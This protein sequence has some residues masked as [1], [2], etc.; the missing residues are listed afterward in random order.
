[1]QTASNVDASTIERHSYFTMARGIRRAC[2]T[3]GALAGIAV[4]LPAS[5]QTSYTFTSGPTGDGF[6]WP[7]SPTGLLDGTSF[8]TPENL[9]F[10][11]D[12][13]N[14]LFFDDQ[15]QVAGNAS[16]ISSD[17]MWGNPT[18]SGSGGIDFDF[19]FSG[20]QEIAF[21][22]A[23][24]AG[25]GPGNTPDELFIYVED[26]EGRAMEVFW[27]LSESFPGFGGFDGFA[28]RITL[29]TIDLFDDYFNVDG[30]PFIDIVYVSI[31]VGDID[32][33]GPSS[34]FAIDNLDL[35]GGNGGGGEVFPSINGGTIDAT[36]V[37]LSSTSLRGV[38]TTT[39]GIEVTNSSTSNTTYSTQLLPG[40]G[41]SDG[42][43]V[44]NA[45]ILAGQ[46]LFAPNIVT[47]DRSLPSATYESDIRVINNG[48]ASDPDNDTTIR[49]RLA[50]APLLSAPSPVD[51]SLGE[52]V[53]LI[54]AAAPANGHR[55][56]VEVTGFA[57]AS[58]FSVSGYDIETPC[59]PGEFIEGDA[60]F[61]R[62][63]QLSGNHNGIFTVALQMTFF[64]GINNDIETFLSDAEP[65]PDEQWTL[66][67]D[68]A[69]M[70]ADSA[71]YDSVTPLGPGLVGVNSQTT[72]ATI[73]GGGSA[74]S[75]NVSMTQGQ[76]ANGSTTD[77]IRDSA[78]VSFTTA[79]PVYAIQMTY[80]DEDLCPAITESN[81]R[82]LYFNGGASDWQLAVNGN[83]DGGSGAT[84]FSGSFDA[85]VA[86]L[87]GSPLSSALGTHGVDTVNNHVW[88]IVD[89]EATFGTGEVGQSCGI[90]G[91]LDDDG[92]V[93]LD[94]Y[95]IWENCAGG[96]GAA[97]MPGC[98][99]ADCDGDTDV[100]LADFASFMLGFGV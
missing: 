89:H 84:F 93:D 65:V 62:F 28:D 20:T 71:P 98:A 95:A 79:T 3:L 41:L 19:F 82:V 23:W 27:S 10:H 69:D 48:N 87:G 59:K 17:A 4:A 33:G 9:H 46:T 16:G 37:T 77:V 64:V 29:N 50:E 74:S 21:D 44:N 61:D 25:G 53:R 49:I 47:L 1:M 54:N 97:A 6:N 81:L 38:G 35:D 39:R 43:Q 58:P 11:N 42:G 90:K 70:S 12:I 51:V 57:I 85:F 7:A 26:I 83:S 60:A 5:A 2:I 18:S 22:F 15:Y 68:L 91:D 72:A 76:A 32:L 56:S 75:G 34:E 78:G 96:P 100:D 40:G 36:G 14:N 73:V 99:D 45:P 8:A 88:A 13:G 92:D 31:Y 55:A 63:G 66:S 24:S 80:R 52:K 94:D 30:G 86:T 67:A